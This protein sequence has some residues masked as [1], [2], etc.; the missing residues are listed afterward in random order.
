MKLSNLFKKKILLV[1]FVRVKREKLLA[2]FSLILIF[3]F[4]FFNLA[5]VGRS[6]VKGIKA[7]N[8]QI[9][10]S[11]D[12]TKLRRKIGFKVL[13]YYEFIKIN[14]PENAKIL[15]PP[16]AMPWPMIGNAAY[17]RY[18][19]YPRHLVSGRE[20][21]PGLDLKKEQIQYI[22]I[23]WGEVNLFQY[24]YTHG[25]PKFSVPAK[26]IIY[27]KPTREMYDYEAVILKKDFSPE[28]IH[29]DWWGLIE[30]D[31]ERL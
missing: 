14:T 26:R 22:L 6:I 5:R 1:G 21:E 19:L 10:F 29:P 11:S 8:R 3:A 23:E 9:I 13:D 25:W 12:E 17:S 31:L 2:Y 7:L 24:G 20:K 18:F 28:D 30:V 27:K 16:Q 15:I 4:L